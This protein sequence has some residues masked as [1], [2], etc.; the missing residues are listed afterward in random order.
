A[1][2][3]TNGSL[4]VTTH[5]GGAVQAR[6]LTT[7]K[8]LK[9]LSESG[10]YRVLLPIQPEPLR[11]RVSVTT[12]DALP[13]DDSFT[14]YLDPPQLATVSLCY[15]AADGE[16]NVFLRDTLAQLLPGREI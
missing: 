6:E 8:P 16:P 10:V 14:A 11:V 15:P 12:P 5:F 4:L 9:V 7:N 1:N 3:G 13:E 2:D